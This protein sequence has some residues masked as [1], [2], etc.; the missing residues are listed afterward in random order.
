MNVSASRL[1]IFLRRLLISMVIV[2]C[3]AARLSAADLSYKITD[4][5]YFE[6]SQVATIVVAGQSLGEV[7]KLIEFRVSHS[8]R[9]DLT[10]G[11]VVRVNLKEANRERRRSDYP[12][13]LK[14]DAE[15]RFVLLLELGGQTKSGEPIY[16]LSRGVRSAREI[17]L[18]SQLAVLGAIKVFLQIQDFKDDRMTWNRLSELLDETNPI[19]VRNALEQFI[20]FRRGEPKLFLSLRPLYDHPSDE[21]RQRAAE[22]SAILLERH[23]IGEIPEHEALLTELIGVARRDA[24]TAPRAAATD[25]LGQFGLERVEAVVKEIARSDPDQDV[26][27]AAERILLRYRAEQEKQAKKPRLRQPPN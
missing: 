22:L 14:L 2:S 27:Y 6:W 21:I 18:E 11:S 19:L 1:T 9:G 23:S 16:R 13:P 3:A 15:S 5:N 20:K 4:L 25:A 7:G 26:R 8:L 17:Q 12:F 24:A 10:V